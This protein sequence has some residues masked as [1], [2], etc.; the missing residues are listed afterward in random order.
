ML[1]SKIVIIL[2]RPSSTFFRLDSTKKCQKK[3][4]HQRSCQHKKIN[5]D[6]GNREFPRKY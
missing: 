6:F 3:Y 2:E 4:V 1:N 5:P